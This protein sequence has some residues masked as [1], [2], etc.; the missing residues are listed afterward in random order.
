MQVSLFTQERSF[1][2][3]KMTDWIINKDANTL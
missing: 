3:L 1:A 2:S